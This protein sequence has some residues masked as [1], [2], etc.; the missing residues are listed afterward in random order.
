MTLHHRRPQSTTKSLNRDSSARLGMIILGV[1]L[2]FFGVL[3]AAQAE[4]VFSEDFNTGTPGEWPDGWYVDNGVWEHG[5]PTVGPADCAGGN[6][7][8]EGDYCLGTVLDSNYPSYT[9]SRLISPTITL[10]NVSGAEEI[11]LRFWQWFAY[12]PYGR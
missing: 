7:S 1:L 6:D 5:I 12:Y 2:I 11:H 4:V 3:S 10:E 8:G 9:D